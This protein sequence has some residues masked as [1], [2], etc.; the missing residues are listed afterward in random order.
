MKNS[1]T[2]YSFILVSLQMICIATLLFAD[3]SP[4]MISHVFLAIALTIA[5]WAFWELR[6][7]FSVFPEPLTQKS[8]VKTGPYAYTRHPMYLALIIWG[9]GKLLSVSSWLVFFTFFTLLIVLICKIRH[10]EKL[11]TKVY[12]EYSKYK[13]KTFAIIPI[14]F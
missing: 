14:I 8:L 4:T 5:I 2:G 10:E 6:R 11:L 3:R 12:P 9:I 13:E 1:P 7:Q